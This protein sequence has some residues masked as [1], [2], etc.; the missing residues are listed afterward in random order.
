MKFG[1]GLRQSLKTRLLT[2]YLE[3]TTGGIHQEWDEQGQTQQH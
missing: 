1:M 2:Q 3:Q